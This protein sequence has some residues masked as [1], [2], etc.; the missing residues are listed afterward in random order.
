M[1]KNQSDHLKDPCGHM[2][3]GPVFSRAIHLCNILF[4]CFHTVK[5][6]QKFK[7]PLDGRP[8][9]LVLKVQFCMR[10]GPT[11]KVQSLAHAGSLFFF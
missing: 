8:L 1:K 3:T 11:P 9:C 10:W 4:C 7:I 2:C 5:I 6:S